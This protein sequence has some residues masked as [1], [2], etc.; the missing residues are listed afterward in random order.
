LAIE[1]INA[2][3]VEASPVA[4]EVV[5]IDGATTRQTT[6]QKLVDAGAPVASQ[7][8]AEAGVNPTKRMTPLTT[9]QAIEALAA[10]VAQGDKADTA[11]QPTDI[12]VSIASSAQGALAD[13]AL[14]PAAIGSSVQGYDIDLA[15]IAAL[16]SAADKVPYAT[17]SGTWAL[18]DLSAAGRALIDDASA[19]AQRTTLGLGTAAV[20][21]SSDFAT[22]S[23]G[24][25]ASTALQPAAIGST[26]QGFDTDLAAIAA[27]TSAANKAPYATGAGTWA[28]M[29]STSVGRSL[30]GSSLVADVRNI[31]DTA[32]YVATRTALKALDTTKD[33]VAILQE[34]GREGIFLW[35]TGDYSTLVTADTQEGIV[36]KAT[37]IAASS[38]AWVRQFSGDMNI[39][40]FGCV[41]DNATD[42]TTALQATIAYCAALGTSAKKALLVPVG[43]FLYT[44][45]NVPAACLGLA[46]N[47]IDRRCSVLRTTSV[48]A[49]AKFVI[50]TFSLSFNNLDIRGS[51]TAFL[52]GSPQSI[53][54]Q[55]KRSTVVPVDF[56]IY[57]NNCF[58][59]DS[60]Y[61]T[62]LWGRGFVFTNCV[63][64]NAR[65]GHNLQW[66]ADGDYTEGSSWEQKKSTG[67]R[68]LVFRDCE[69][70]AMSL[71]LVRNLGDNAINAEIKM[72][73]VFSESGDSLLSGML[74]EGSHITG[75]NVSGATGIP[76]QITGGEKYR[77]D[78]CQFT[79]TLKASE[80]G[81]TTCV[82]SMSGTHTGFVIDGLT[83]GNCKEH[84][85]EMLSGE[86]DGTVKN[87]DIF[88]VSLSSAGTYSGIVV[89]GTTSA[90]KINAENIKLN[91]TAAALTVIRMVT[92]GT[93]LTYRAIQALGAATPLFGG[94][95][96]SNPAVTNLVWANDGA[97]GAPSY[98]FGSDSDTGFWRAGSGIVGYSAN[99]TEVLRFTATTQLWGRTTNTTTTAGVG[100][101]VTPAG[102]F[103]NT[104]SSGT[105]NTTH[106]RFYNDAGAT[107][108]QVGSIT[109][110]G[111]A[112][113]FNTSSDIRLKE[114]F[115]S[116]DPALLDQIKVYDFAWKIDGTRAYGVIAQEV[117]EIAPSVVALGET[118]D[119][120]MAVD[121]SKFV[122]LLIA[123]VQ[124]LRERL[125]ALETVH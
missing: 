91:N 21:A 15:A 122:P 44:T 108:T 120:M 103:I 1:R 101:M 6:I 117:L 3:P 116:I 124:D 16:T 83:V 88:E 25:L 33:L 55:A 59:S 98:S 63:F 125:A 97:V 93:V 18:A 76:L 119:D 50:D 99:G 13:S 34:S 28:L 39:E 45:L 107:P 36:V 77:I 56:D 111:S 9:A 57:F 65:Y 109:T 4:S 86:F 121:Y 53:I 31:L 105:A 20:A 115:Q 89:G 7:A 43:Q 5:P 14:Q 104:F 114:D 67:F 47:G 95:G 2:L 106:N 78:D 17:G 87:I 90:T 79:G 22:A 46:I 72:Q 70:H 74:G 66:P 37:A 68:R 100:V 19:S 112:T 110:N 118:E 96:T 49:G 113:A 85:I 60:W 11:L 123:T 41:G 27:L 12:G 48:T 80:D 102:P 29:D 71:A 73:H 30:M 94:A 35:K 75:C 23:Q 58:M 42:N 64:S 54:I 82:I 32:P 52:V 81:A 10:S 61:L 40:W 51:T 69:V 8:E 84:G 26:V 24:A 38:G 62:D 92:S